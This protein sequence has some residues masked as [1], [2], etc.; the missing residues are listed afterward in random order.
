LA[1]TNSSLNKAMRNNPR[2]MSQTRLCHSL[3]CQIMLNQ[4]INRLVDSFW[5][6]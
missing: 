3:S 2:G 1:K 4:H 6:F 5:I